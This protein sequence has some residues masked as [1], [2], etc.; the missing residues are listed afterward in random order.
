MERS[1][2]LKEIRGFIRRRIKS[3]FFTFSVVMILGFSVAILLT[4]I[5]RSEATILIEDQQIPEGFVE[6]TTNE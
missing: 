6:P 5:Y 3:F 2:D 4:P 1:L